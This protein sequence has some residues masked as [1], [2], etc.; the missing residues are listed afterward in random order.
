MNVKA[1]KETLERQYPGVNIKETTVTNREVTEI[2]GE[3]DRKLVDSERDVA[4]VVADR[5]GEHQHKIITEEYEVIKGSLKVFRNGQATDL[6]PGQTITIEPGTWHSVE[7]NETWFFCYSVPDW[8][9]GDFYPRTTE[10]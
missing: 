8:F 4:V 5:S 9:P 2:V 7:G 10:T 3:I 6:Q 1:V